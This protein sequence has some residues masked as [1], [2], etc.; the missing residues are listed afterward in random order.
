[1]SGVACNTNTESEVEAS[2]LDELTSY[3]ARSSG[4]DPAQAKRLVDDVLSYLSESVDDFVRR[5]HAVLLRL[6][7]RN[8]E[9]YTTIAAE[10]AARRFPPPLLSIRQIR[11]IIYG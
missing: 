9:I 11:R 6:G 3:V 10:L 2:D 7:R 4:L 1:L 8:P 5:R